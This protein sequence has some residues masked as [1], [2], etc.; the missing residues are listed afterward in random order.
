MLKKAKAKK[1]NRTNRNLSEKEGDVKLTL[2]HLATSILFI[3]L[4]CLTYSTK[5]MFYILYEYVC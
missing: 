3:S 5:N 4:I 1:Q 2:L